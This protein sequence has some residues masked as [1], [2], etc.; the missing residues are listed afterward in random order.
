[1]LIVVVTSKSSINR[2]SKLL[3]ELYEE[4]NNLKSV[5]ISLKEKEDNVIFGENFYLVSGKEYIDEEIFDIKFK[6]Y[7]DSFFQINKKQAEKIYSKVLELLG[8]YNDK[9]LIDAFSGT[10]TISLILSKKAKYVYGIEMVSSSVKS[11]IKTSK[12]NNIKNTKFINLKVE[13]ALSEIMKKE[14]VDYIV[15]DPP[16]KGI[17]ESVLREVIKEKFLKLYIFHV[18]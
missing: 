13:E 5:Y 17:S 18:I 7:P 10:G 8:D 11:A 1:M 9:V 14:K 4:N 12:E 6:I 16:R 2:L 3:Q 15:F